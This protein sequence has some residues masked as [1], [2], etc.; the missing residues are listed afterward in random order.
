MIARRSKAAAPS[1]VAIACW[2]DLLGYGG[3]IDKAGF[4]PAHPLAQP[5]LRRLRAFHRIVSKHSSAGFP[6]LVMNDGA[7]AYSNVE[8]VRSDKVWRF[9][10]RCWALYEE[11]TATDRASGGPGLRGVIAVGLRAKGS[12]R[13]I[14]AQDKELTAI[15]EDLAAGRIDEKKALADARKVRR[16]FDIIPQLQANFAFTRAYEAE[17]AGSAAGFPGPNLFLD[18]AVFA[19]GVP[20]WISAGELIAWTP[21]KASL[22]TSF[23]AVRGIDTVNDETAHTALRTGQQLLDLLSHHSQQ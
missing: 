11:A 20:E 17:Q 7:V 10:E 9:V 15:I 2:L 3:A 6:T 19:A 23:I 12:N 4:D 18:A 5:P 14:V 16:V 13:G 1:Y 21:K 22:A 8:L